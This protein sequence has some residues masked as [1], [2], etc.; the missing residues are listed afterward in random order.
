MLRHTQTV[1]A[2]AVG[3]LLACAAALTRADDAKDDAKKLEGDWNVVSVDAGGRLQDKG[4][5]PKQVAIRG[6]QITLK[7]KD[8]D[9][10]TYRFTVDPSQ[11]PKTMD[12]FQKDDST[13]GGIYELDGDDLKLCF[14]LVPSERKEGERL[15]R[16]GSFDTKDQPV[17][18]V[19]ARREKH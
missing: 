7:M 11:K 15:K 4:A 19:T 3:M 10:P 9:G 1:C 13:I 14:P 16:P 5:G 2:L 18:V 6:D 8:G 17:V 12:W